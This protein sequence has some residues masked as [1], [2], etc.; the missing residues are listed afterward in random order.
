MKKTVFLSVGLIFLISL[1]DISAQQLIPNS[2]V[3]GVCY[4]GNKVNRIYIPPPKGITSKFGA[5]GGGVINVS[6][7]GFTSSAK[8]AVAYAVNILEA[9]LPA[10]MNIFVKAS[11]TKISTSGVL[12]NSSITGFAAGWGIDALVPESFYPVTVAEKIA[13]KDLNEISEA[14]VELVLNSSVNWYLG[15]DGNTPT[16]KYDLVTVVIH[17]LC[18]GLGFF[19]SMDAQ[20]S[21]GTYGLGP[22]P[23]IYD[24]FVEN[25]T[26]KRLTDT[27]AFQQNTTALY[28]ELVGGQLYFSG[29]VTKR[30]LSGSRARLYAPSTWD[31]GSSVSHLDE[32]RTLPEN[33]LMTPYIDLG[34]AI[35]NP[36]K[37]TMSILGDLGWINTRITPGQLKD[38]EDNISEVQVTASIKS[39]TLYNKNKVGLVYSFDGFKTS[40]TL[41]MISPLSNNSYNRT[42]PIPGYNIKLDYYI[43]AEDTFLRL[44][45]SPS[46]AAE[47]PYTM[48]IGTDTVKPVISHTPNEYFFEKID[49][50]LFNATVTDNLGIDTVYI[51]YN[52][53]GGPSGFFGLKAS[54]DDIFRMNFNVNDKVLKGGDKLNYRIIA[55]DGAAG[56]NTRTLPSSGYYSIQIESLG[57]VL[58]SYSTDFSDAAADFFNSGFAILQPANFNSLS[59]NTE[60]PYKSPDKDDTTLEFSSVL[61]HPI[62]FDPSGMVISYKELVLVEPGEEGSVFGFSDFYDYV[63]VEG[64]KNFG[65]TWFY[66]TDGYDCRFIPSWETAY[67][68]RIDGQNSTYTGRESM[69]AIHNLYPRFPDL[70]S[71]GDS[72][73][74]R[75]RLFSDPYAN[76]WGWVI[77][78]LSIYPLV[79]Q[80][81][82]TIVKDLTIYPNPGNG[83]VTIRSQNGNPI[84]SR[85][86]SVY[87]STGQVI[88]NKQAFPDSQLVI[89]LSIYPSGIY[90]ITIDTNS[91]REIF[92]YSLIR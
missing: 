33:S 56:R 88:I 42:I 14:D 26:E 16:N 8:A 69:M 12:G 68:S 31:P 76:G 83:R 9:M 17:E 29:P 19:D 43:Y 80:A 55:I 65:K 57:S 63:I 32:L 2:S 28:L 62:V 23:I 40:D 6:Y 27:V 21:V 90:F 1:L 54:G 45:R 18:H 22:L 70:I 73:L 38:T 75:F 87:N 92:K 39:D 50:I 10:D 51:E 86:V 60:H 59:L 71:S 58:R 20:N 91:G 67:N 81:E 41:I 78:D 49:S 79:D 7:S 35:H 24:T 48:F 47:R 36:G 82:E 5:K 66:L 30:Y 52:I 77:D 64:S 44:Y 53:N 72:L 89:D 61:R 25:L 13:G 85:S 3:T 46:L 37:L 4:A 84:Q 15:T 11:W 34:E 74:I